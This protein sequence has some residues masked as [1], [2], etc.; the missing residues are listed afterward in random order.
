LNVLKGRIEL[1][2][3]RFDKY[4]DLGRLTA[5]HT[6][7]GVNRFLEEMQEATD[8]IEKGRNSQLHL[9]TLYFID[10]ISTHLIGENVCVS[11]IPDGGYGYSAFSWPFKHILEEY[12]VSDPTAGQHPTVVSYLPYEQDSTLLNALFAHEIAHST[13]E[14]EDLVDSVLTAKTSDFDGAFDKLAAELA[15]ENQAPL[16]KAEEKLR[17]RVDSWVTELLCDSLATY[18]L[19]PSYLFSIAPTVI[20]TGLDDFSD[21]HPPTAIRV[22]HILDALVNAGWRTPLEARIPTVMKWLDS[23]ASVTP[24]A[25]NGIENLCLE[26]CDL[27]QAQIERIAADRLTGAVFE[28]G[29]FNE[30]VDEMMDFFDQRILPAQMR[31]RSAADRRSILLGGWLFNLKED[32]VEDIA[33]AIEDAEFQ[34]FL[35]AALEMSFVLEAWNSR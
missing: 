11:P 27:F 7:R 23:V 28:A 20:A 1:S 9:G 34:G 10:Q 19:G 13:V 22:K 24:S 17:D 14:E 29:D 18:Y 2:G 21:T 5:L 26:T 4:D 3:E 25:V 30:Q 32:Q 8:W 16:S 12:G 6:M 31:D 33:T 15:A 35:A